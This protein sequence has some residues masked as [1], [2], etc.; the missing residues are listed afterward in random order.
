MIKLED[1]I[2][3]GIEPMTEKSA[4]N[5]SKS[6]KVDYL[7]ISRKGRLSVPKTLRVKE[8]LESYEFFVPLLKHEGNKPAELYLYLMT[9][10]EAEEQNP[11]G[12]KQINFYESGETKATAYLELR[13]Q[14]TIL[15]FIKDSENGPSFKVNRFRVEGN[16]LILSLRSIEEVHKGSSI[17]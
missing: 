14:L 15:G 9:R 1:L 11:K 16:I 6:K 10:K 4:R 2:K 8:K 17:K 12:K 3:S 5:F 7:V 13:T